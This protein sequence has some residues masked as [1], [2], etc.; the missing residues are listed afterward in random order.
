MTRDA[1]L[2]EYCD[3]NSMDSKPSQKFVLGRMQSNASKKSRTNRQIHGGSKT[4]NTSSLNQEHNNT[5][6]FALMS[7]GSFYGTQMVNQNQQKMSNKSRES[8]KMNLL[9]KSSS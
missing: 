3:N 4:S 7:K 2:D 1:I 9:S 8:K 5:A 6:T